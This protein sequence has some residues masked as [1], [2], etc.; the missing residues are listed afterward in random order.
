MGSERERRI[1]EKEGERRRIEAR[2]G[3]MSGEKGIVIGKEATTHRNED[4]T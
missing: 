3:R 2:G 4:I 1:E